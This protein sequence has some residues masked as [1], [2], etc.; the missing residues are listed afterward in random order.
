MAGAP[1]ETETPDDQLFGVKVEL[2]AGPFAD[3]GSLSAFERA[4]A[5][6]PRVEDVYVRRL[7]ADRALIELTLGE[8]GPLIAAMRESLP[9]EFAVRDASSTTLVLDITSPEAAENRVANSG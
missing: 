6:M 9:Y 4:L 5:L 1:T 2:D 8:E 3:F 7:A